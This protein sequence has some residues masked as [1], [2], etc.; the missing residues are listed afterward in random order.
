[1]GLYGRAVVVFLARGVN[2][3]RGGSDLGSGHIALLNKFLN[4]LTLL[5]FKVGLDV[6]FRLLWYRGFRWS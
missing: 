6:G 3:D 2:R 1:M 5:A 4:G